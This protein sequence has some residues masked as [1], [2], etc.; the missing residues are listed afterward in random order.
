[1]A[2]IWCVYC[3]QVRKELIREIHSSAVPLTA[4]FIRGASHMKSGFLRKRFLT[5]QKN[6]SFPKYHNWPNPNTAHRSE[7][8]IYG[9]KHGGGDINIMLSI[10]PGLLVKWN[11]RYFIK[12][13]TRALRLKWKTLLLLIGNPVV[14]SGNIYIPWTIQH[15]PVFFI[16][17]PPTIPSVS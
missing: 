5:R 9:V 12:N 15:S 8:T 7:Y 3:D 4:I 1:M 11:Q 2:N 16:S 6:W 17:H 10:T 13:N 14:I